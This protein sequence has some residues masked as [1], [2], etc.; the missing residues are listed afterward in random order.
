MPGV[1]GQVQSYLMNGRVNRPTG[2]VVYQRRLPRLRESLNGLR[3][4][5]ED[6]GEDHNPDAANGGKPHI[7][8]TD[9]AKYHLTQPADGN[10]QAMTTIERASISVWLTPAIMVWHRQ[11]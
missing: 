6:N 3:Q 9:T 11:R 5:V 8:T 7:Q 1:T 10:H 2:P 4:A